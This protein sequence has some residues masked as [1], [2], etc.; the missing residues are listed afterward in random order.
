MYAEIFATDQESLNKLIISALEIQHKIIK[1]LGF[2]L[3]VIP[4]KGIFII[5][6]SAETDVIPLKDLGL[7]LTACG[8]EILKRRSIQGSVQVHNRERQ[9]YQF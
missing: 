8:T 1:T 3:E 5:A 9:F 7:M 6:N 2:I 4:K